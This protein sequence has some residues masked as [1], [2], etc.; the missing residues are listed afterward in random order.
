MS[1]DYMQLKVMELATQVYVCG[2]IFES[3][4]KIAAEQGIRTVVNNR[5]DHEVAGQPLTADLQSAAESLGLKFVYLPVK[6]GSITPQDVEDFR[7]VAGEIER[8][9]LIFCR[10][11]ARSTALWNMCGVD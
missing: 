4:L 10:T 6:S 5:P 3:D 11:G 7:K 1:S 9:A 8:P 2:Q